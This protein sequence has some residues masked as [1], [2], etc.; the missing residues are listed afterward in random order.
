MGV[1]LIKTA[2]ISSAFATRLMLTPVC[3]SVLGVAQLGSLLQTL[4]SLVQ[5]KPRLGWHFL[6]TARLAHHSIFF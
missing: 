1:G 6:L 4:G 5:T 3:S 2:L